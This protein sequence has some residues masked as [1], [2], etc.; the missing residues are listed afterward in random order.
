M[1]SSDMAQ[2]GPRGGLNASEAASAPEIGSGEPRTPSRDAQA[3]I[4]SR[5]VPRSVP[6]GGEECADEQ[7]TAALAAVAR[8]VRNAQTATRDDYELASAAAECPNCGDPLELCPDG[9]GN[10]YCFGCDD[11]DQLH[12]DDLPD[13]LE[14][15]PLIRDRAGEIQHRDNAHT[16]QRDGCP[17][18]CEAAVRARRDR[19]GLLDS[20]ARLRA[21]RDQARRW[22]V[23]LEN[24]LA[25]TADELATTRRLLEESRNREAS[26]TA[27]TALER[28]AQ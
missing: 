17:G 21:E 20:N 24:Q 23:E 26:H 8:A 2:H 15:N 19:N 11:I 5:D 13:A 27:R 3:G 10:T 9:C 22:A 18:D 25:A 28:P 7:W 14:D 4:Q 6:R 1:T 16:Q 12:A